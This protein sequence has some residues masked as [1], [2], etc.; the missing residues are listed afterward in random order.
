MSDTGIAADPA[1]AAA[2]ALAAAANRP[3]YDG[4]DTTTVGHIQNRGWDKIDAK[5]AALNAVKS[6]MEAEKHLGVPADQLLRMPKDAAD[7]EGW[8]R[9]NERFGVPKEAKDYDFS[10]IKL[11]GDKPLPAALTEALA[12]ALLAAHIGKDV[13]PDVVKAIASY[14]N[15]QETATATDKTAA[16]AADR[17]ALRINWGTNVEA[18]LLIAKQAATA[19]NVSEEAVKTLEDT[20]GYGKVMEM[21]RLIGTKIGEDAFVSNKA[22]GGSGVMSVDQAKATLQERQNDKGWNDKLMAGDATT[23][24]EFNNLTTLIA[25]ARRQ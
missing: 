23:M 17:E 13:A 1:A 9:V 2:A 20:I 10:T 19:L 12:P 14:L 4:A 16:L 25:A 7:A 8:G 15:T 6:H 5:T 24:K 22:P 21:F 3:W 11:T 18:N